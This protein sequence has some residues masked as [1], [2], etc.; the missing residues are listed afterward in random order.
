MKISKV[1]WFLEGES[2]LECPLA[3]QRLH[4]LPKVVRPSPSTIEKGF[5]NTDLLTTKG[6]AG[7]SVIF[8]QWKNV[9]TILKSPSCYDFLRV[10]VKLLM[11]F[12]DI[13]IASSRSF[14][15]K[16]FL[17]VVN[18]YQ[19]SVGRMAMVRRRWGATGI[20]WIVRTQSVIH[21]LRNILI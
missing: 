4:R 13:W 16:G 5:T 15:I 19:V 12:Y 9:K 3:G 2:P 1:P 8:F 21:G 11:D 20:G 17:E 7:D 10:K 18:F 14:V 6:S